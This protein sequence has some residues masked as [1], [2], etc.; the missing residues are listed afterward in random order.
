MFTAVPQQCCFSGR[1]SSDNAP[2]SESGMSSSS[3]LPAPFMFTGR[4]EAYSSVLKAAM[5]CLAEVREIA[6]IRR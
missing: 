6:L 2:M 5:G 1:S 3:S 4:A